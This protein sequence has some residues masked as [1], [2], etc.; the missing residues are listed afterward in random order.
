M[1]VTETTTVSW[2]SRLGGSLKG[3]LVGL[4]MFVAGFPVLFWNEGN[5][6][7][8]AKALDEG[9]NACVSVESN[10]A[11]DAANDGSLV[12]MTGKATTGD[13]LSD[14]Q[15]AVSATAI[16]LSR[17]V[18]MY[19]WDED[20]HTTEKK[21]VGGSVT[22]TTTYTHKLVWSSSVLDTPSHPEPGSDMTN[23]GAMEFESGD[24]FAENVAFGAFRLSPD[25]IR[26]IDDARPYVFPTNWVC[27]VA[28]AVRNGEY[29]YVP[30]A[31]T[32]NNDLNRRD[33]VAEPRVGDMRIRFSVV[34][35]HEVSLVARQRGDT[36]IPYVAKSGK[37][38]QMLSDGVKDA[39]EMFADARSGN[40]MLTW[41]LRLGGFLL[42]FLGLST[43]LKPL[44]VLADVL[45]ILGDIVEIGAGI[46]AALV[47][48]VCSLVTI[49]I[50]WLF[51]RPVIGIALLV[52][53]G[54]FVW[55][56]RQKKSK[57]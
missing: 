46:V 16:R 41:L 39:A 38:V 27:P 45:P 26:S 23:P 18:E 32:R 1:A 36:F 43:I 6:V 8:T 2:G 4:A 56:L 51:Y 31:A 22:K 54:F 47:A 52:V 5:Y 20:S 49:A 55:K 37:K 53:A 35:P 14:A 34:T 40:S 28:K 13:V 10:A 17:K 25:Q 11:I 42:M 57:K 33:V 12:H 3:I 29:V 15:F 19:Q 50:A 9:E 7:K 21:N 44:S 24:Q 48:L 30:N